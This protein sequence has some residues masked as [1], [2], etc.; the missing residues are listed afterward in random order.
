MNGWISI[1]RKIQEHWIWQDEKRLK[2]W[3]TIILNVNHEPKKFP[4]GN[5]VLVCNPGQSFRSIEQW[6]AMFLCSKKTT[7]KFFEMLK[8]DDMIQCEIVGKGNRR[9]HLLSVVNWDEYQ[10]K[11]NEVS[12]PRKPECSVNGNPNVTSNNKDNNENN[13]NNKNTPLAPSVSTG[14]KI[15]KKIKK[16]SQPDALQ[17]PFSGSEF[18]IVWH[19]LT[20]LSKW[21]NKPHSAIQKSLDQL[22]K[23]DELF[24]IKL[25]EDA[26]AGNW[27]GV[28]FTDTDD[29]FSKWKNS[30]N[31][32]NQN[33]KRTAANP[34]TADELAK[35]RV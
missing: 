33:F 32:N 5:E 11:E 9:K 10:K 20:T 18:L 2:W 13:E 15:E 6:T 27:S 25:I 1:Y 35:D 30:T 17:L 14:I 16:R 19:Q 29:K 31:G 8:N 4:V 3:L 7:I 28:V 26:H 34:A 24:A 23:Y 12:T 21:K 22:A